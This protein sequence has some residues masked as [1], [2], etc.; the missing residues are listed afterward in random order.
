MALFA[1]V[2]ATN[3]GLKPLGEFDAWQLWTR[4]AV[5][6]FWYP[7]IPVDVFGSKVAYMNLQPD[8]PMLL[9]MLEAMQFRAGGRPDPSQAHATTW[10]LFVAG[11]WALAYLASRRARPSVAVGIPAGLSIMLAG[12]ALTAYADVPVAL[13]IGG[14]VLCIGVSAPGSDPREDL[15]LG[16]VLLGGCGWDQE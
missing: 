1:I 4:K 9:P 15:V 6:L 11:I 8:Y 10:I 12:P 2:V 13:F 5:L 16:G 7:G 14:G 3:A